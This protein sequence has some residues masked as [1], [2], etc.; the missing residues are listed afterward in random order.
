MAQMTIAIVD[1]NGALVGE[2]QGSEA[3]MLANIKDGQFP[4]LTPRPSE[5]SYWDFDKKEWVV[6]PAKPSASMT[7]SFKDKKW[8]DTRSLDE[9]KAQRWEQAKRWRDNTEFSGFVF[10]GEHYDSDVRSQLR[11]NTA[12]SLNNDTTWVTSDNRSVNMS[13]A[14]LK[15]MQQAL[16]VFVDRVNRSSQAIK[17][18]I[19]SATSIAAVDAVVFNL[20]E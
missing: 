18:E 19:F 3:F 12:A 14:D 8:I 9:A 10:N 2:A 13:A 7:F 16:A 5:F 4:V 11:V 15:G 6:I 1:A 17:S 20:L